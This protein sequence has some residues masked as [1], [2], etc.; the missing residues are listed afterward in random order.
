L[1]KTPEVAERYEEVMNANIEK[2]YAKKVDSQSQVAG[3][4]W[5]LPH[6]PVIREDKQTTKVRIV[7]DSAAREQGTS[8]N[9]VMLTG[10][11]L[12][13]EVMEILLCFLFFIM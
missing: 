1:L 3:P 10:P 12:Q 5:Y 2:G 6:F 8:L 7:F 13:K 9:D 4:A 11:K